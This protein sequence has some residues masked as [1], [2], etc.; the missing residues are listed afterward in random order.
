MT[1]T[2]PISVCLAL[3]EPDWE[4]WIERYVKKNKLPIT[5]TQPAPYRDIVIERV[6]TSMPSVLVL[7][8]G[9]PRDAQSPSFDAIVR[10]IRTNFKGCRIIIIA[11][12]DVEPGDDFLRRMV[13]R[14]VYD[15]L[16][17][18]KMTLKDVVEFILKPREYDYAEVLQG[19]EPDTSDE[20]TGV[21][22]YA[23]PAKE[24]SQ[25]KG[26]FG[27]RSQSTQEPVQ[28]PVS[29][30]V[31]QPVPQQMS[32]PVSQPVSQNV[33]T[34]A[35]QETKQPASTGTTVLTSPVPQISIAVPQPAPKKEE[36]RE[37]RGIIFEKVEEKKKEYSQ[38]VQTQNTFQQQTEQ[39]QGYG[40][41]QSSQTQ[42]YS[43]DVSN[44]QHNQSSHPVAQ[45]SVL[46][47]DDKMMIG[48]KPLSTGYMPKVTA[49]VGAR[50]GV[51]CTTTI[52][53]TAY[54]L[55]Q[56]GKRVVVLDAVWNEKCIFDRL[57][58]KHISTGLGNRGGALPN[59]FKSS[60]YK[61]FL[62][63]TGKVT[64]AVQFLELETGEFPE[65]SGIITTIS[66]LSGYDNVLIDMSVAFYR[67]ILTGILSL[68]DKVVAVTLQDG[69]ELMVLRNYLNVYQTETPIFNKLVLVLNRANPKLS[70]SVS[71]TAKYIITNDIVVIPSDT[72][73]FIR[74]NSEK[75][76]YIGKSKIVKAYSYLATKI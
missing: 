73:G 1:Q 48:N 7:S 12:S 16:Y 2:T 5:F 14:G 6:A 20:H 4:S 76:N 23:P 17:G 53:N 63:K 56:K 65:D 30:P 35:P 45:N 69:Y 71:D 32:Q 67:R 66:K 44:S 15:I 21:S 34:P 70:P 60:F 8:R 28:K 57:G 37:P 19:L 59:G 42:N 49:F 24:E 54:T 36:K 55:A 52:I 40:Q 3:G 58:L 26:L 46:T 62:D 72:N 31:A 61:T 11:G 13:N 27:F 50:Q 10:K 41:T 51:G 25:K 39:V 22:M 18:E 47:S 33:Y 38:P 64:G 68:A 75:R 9:L 29:Q 43:P 74:A